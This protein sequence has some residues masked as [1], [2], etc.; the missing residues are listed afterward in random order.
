MNAVWRCFCFAAV[1]AR[2]VAVVG[3]LALAPKDLL[4]L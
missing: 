4:A 2:F 1:A 3:L